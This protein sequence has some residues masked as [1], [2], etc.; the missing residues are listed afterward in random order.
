MS[1]KAFHLGKPC[2][3][4]AFGFDDRAEL[5]KEAT[6]PKEKAAVI[7][8]WATKAIQNWLLSLCSIITSIVFII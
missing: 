3:A 2:L 1:A 7:V 6:L 8:G 4:A 5:F